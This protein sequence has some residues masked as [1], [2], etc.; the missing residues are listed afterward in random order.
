MHLRRVWARNAPGRCVRAQSARYQRFLSTIM[1]KRSGQIGNRH[2][3]GE[4]TYT[5]VH[6]VSTI[7]AMS[8][9]SRRFFVIVERKRR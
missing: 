2:D 4:K 6:Y 5:A 7:M 9:L 1:K 8:D 3:G